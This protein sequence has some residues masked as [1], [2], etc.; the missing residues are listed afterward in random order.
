MSVG[1]D[2]YRRP[3]RK[4]VLLGHEPASSVVVERV[5]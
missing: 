1:D 4:P 5:L 2:V 3:S